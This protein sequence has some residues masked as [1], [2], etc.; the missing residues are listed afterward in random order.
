MTQVDQLIPSASQKI[1][2]RRKIMKKSPKENT[3]D[4]AIRKHLSG[5]ALQAAEIIFKDP[6]VHAFQEHANTVSIKRLGYNDHGPVHMRKAALNAIIL[7]KLLVESGVE[8]SLV[9][10]NSGT[11]ED[12]LVAITVSTLLH[13]LG[14][15]IARDSHEMYSITLAMPI[16]ERILKELYPDKIDKQVIVKATIIECIAGHMATRR[17]HSIEAGCVLIGDG[18]D[19]EKGRA[20]I[21]TLIKSAPQIGDIHRYSAS[22]IDKLRIRKGKDKP[23]RINVEMSESVGFFQIEEVLFPK[24]KFSPIKQYI[25]L[26]AGVKDEDPV[27]YL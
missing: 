17:I 20:R 26:I 2:K 24:I 6:E 12:S 16:I 23:I 14:M 5:L 22:A 13:D 15:S 7:A 21:P 9:K 18:C 3:I 10:D 8:L 11:T 25:E 1:F 19:M 27:R 4:N